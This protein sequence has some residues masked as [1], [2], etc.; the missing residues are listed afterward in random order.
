[1]I[2]ALSVVTLGLAQP[3]AMGVATEG[4]VGGVVTVAIH[5]PRLSNIAARLTA[6]AAVAAALAARD[7]GAEYT[8]VHLR[9]DVFIAAHIDASMAVSV[10]NE[11]HRRAYDLS[12]VLTLDRVPSLDAKDRHMRKGFSEQIDVQCLAAGVAVDLTL[13][14]SVKVQTSPDGTTWTDRTTTVVTAASGLVRAVLSTVETAALDAGTTLRVRV[15]AV[16]AASLTRCF[17]DDADLDIK[18][19]VT[20]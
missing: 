8:N 2:S 9:G 17:P 12:T 7:V 16:D 3:T 14:T 11:A 10:V 6:T 19:R 20:A 13:W 1:M 15:S 4:L 5:A 18:L